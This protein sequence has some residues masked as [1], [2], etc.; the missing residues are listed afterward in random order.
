MKSQVRERAIRR[1]WAEMK[2]RSRA[3]YLLRVEKARAKGEAR[4]AFRRKVGK[5]NGVN[6]VRV[7][8]LGALIKGVAPYVIK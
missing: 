3:A 2:E 1:N 5:E 8:L 4:R 6:Y 7:K